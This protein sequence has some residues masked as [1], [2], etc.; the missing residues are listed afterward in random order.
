MD[1]ERKG[2]D[3][4]AVLFSVARPKTG[5][6]LHYAEQGEPGGEPLLLLHGYADSWFSWSRVLPLLPPSF[7]AYAIDQRGHGDSER[8]ASGYGMADFAADAIAFME[9]AGLPP[10]TLVGHSMGSFIARRVAVEAPERVK[11]LVLIGAGANSRTAALVELE[12]EVRELTDPVAEDFI[13]AFQA[14]TNPTPRDF[15][16]GIIAESKKLPARVWR[17]ALAGLAAPD[18]SPRGDIETPAL[19]LHGGNDGVFPMSEQDLLMASLPNGI[20]KVYPG[21]GH[22]VHWE[23]P[24]RVAEDLVGF[25]AGART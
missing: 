5:V 25:I 15:M 11:R 20:L 1:H 22:G 12:Q 3:S 24:E 18:A 7:H 17:D 2:Y 9:Y 19:V 6:A 21:I 10:V 13:R 14:T 4:R 8:P 23:A 16:E